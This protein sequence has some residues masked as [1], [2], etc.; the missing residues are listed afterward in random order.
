M[1]EPQR[2]VPL[3][4]V[5]PEPLVPVETEP[6]RPSPKSSPLVRVGIVTGT[7][8]L[9][10][11]GAMAAMGAS[12]AP[13]ANPADPATPPPNGDPD[14]GSGPGRWGTFGMAGGMDFGGLGQ[15]AR[16]ISI[17]SIAGSSLDL[18]TADGWT[19][20]IA[21][22]GTTTITKAG[23]TITV[24]DLAVGDLIRFAETKATD[25]TYSITKIVV[26][27]PSLA[28]SVTAKTADTI[29]ITRRDGTTATI[30]VTSSTTYTVQG[31]TSPTLAD[32]AVGAQV[33]AEGTLRTDGSLDASS[34]SSGFGGHGGRGLGHDGADP[35]ASPNPSAAPG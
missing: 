21:V 9:V 33:R 25:G 5:Q 24:S 12:P 7:A 32:I 35:D 8:A 6:V 16:A 29:T 30:H 23:A 10:L 28:G 11:V 34:A 13:T 15:G 19:R 17:T 31:L 27:M 22:T 18:T 20:T 2:F 26:V 1:T 4:P 14:H 3:V